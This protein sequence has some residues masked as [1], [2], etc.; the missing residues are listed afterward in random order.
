MIQ[1]KTTYPDGTTKVIFNTTEPFLVEKEMAELI[2]W[3]YKALSENTVHPLIAI[4][5]FAYEFLSIHPYQDGNGRLSRLLTTL[6]LLRSGYSFIAYVSFEQIIEQ[7]KKE[8]YQAL[9]E[10][11]KDRHHHSEKLDRWILFFLGCLGE[12]IARL[13][14]KLKEYR[15]LGGYLNERQKKI[16]AFIK[17]NQPVKIGDIKSRFKEYH[18]ETIKKDLQYLLRE[19][20]IDKLGVKKGT[21]YKIKNK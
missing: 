14:T 13:E 19:F 2:E 11:Q 15:D 9:M 16:L 20:E 21:I 4:A 12:L 1:D 10:G 7:K 6:L 18:P 8:Y 17:E 5:A 3:T